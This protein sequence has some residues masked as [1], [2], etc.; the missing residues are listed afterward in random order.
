MRGSV[1][2][3][4]QPRKRIS[5][6]AA[7][8]SPVPASLSNARRG[9]SAAAAIGS[10]LLAG[11]GAHGTPTAPASAY[12]SGELASLDPGTPLGGRPAPNFTLTDQ[13]G[14]AVSLSQFKGRAV[15]VSFDD[16]E[17]TTI[18]PLT[19]ATMVEALDLLGPAASQ[20]QLVGINANPQH[21]SVADV[22]A[23][24]QAHGMENR[25][26]FLTGSLPQLQQVWKA[27]GVDVQI[28]QGNIDHTPAVYV[29]DPQGGESRLFLTSSDYGVTGLEAG[30]LA[31]AISAVLPGHPQVAKPNLALGA[32]V[33]S[34]A[35]TVRLPALAPGGSPV[36]LGPSSP[37]LVVFFDSWASGA[38]EQL[39]ALN[40]YSQAAGARHL[41][42]L[43]AVDVQPTEP[44]LAAALALAPVAQGT[45]RYPVAVDPNGRV[46]DAYGVADIPWLVL[47]SGGRVRWSHD[48]WLAPAALEQ[49]VTAT[50]A[51]RAKSTGTHVTGGAAAPTAAPPTAAG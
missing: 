7:V 31:Q 9:A 17:C 30:A 28:L 16:D 33:A 41:P 10:L 38:A 12:T 2:G 45:L 11:C 39:Q 1:P 4:H 48:G 42:A 51:P 29:I 18:C 14:K 6:G 27:Y 35:D 40:A 37:H 5:G 46:A 49:Q 13:F 47:V 21:I 36:V 26:L 8:V 15:V 25:W 23:Y 32:P 19:G 50:L 3:K 24:S 43:L 34:P 22:A 44:S 20:V